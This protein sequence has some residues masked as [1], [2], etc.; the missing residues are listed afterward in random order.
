MSQRDRLE[1]LART[2]WHSP[3][4]TTWGN[5]AVQSASVLLI[6]ALILNRL[7]TIEIAAFYLFAAT[8]TLA[9]LLAQRVSLSFIRLFAFANAGA[10][11]LGPIQV[12]SSSPDEGRLG[13]G[14][15]VP[16]PKP[17]TGPNWQSMR[18]VFSTAGLIYLS[19]ALFAMLVSGLLSAYG[20]Y[21]LQRDGPPTS[22]LWTALIVVSVGSA[23]DLTLRRY[24]TVLRGLDHVA[25]VNRWNTLLSAGRMLAM[26]LVLW[27]GGKL[28][29][30]VIAQQLLL[31]ISGLCNRWLLLRVE[32][33]FRTA[34]TYR[35][36]QDILSAAWEPTWRGLVAQLSF[37]GIAQLSGIIFTRWG[38][39]V[40]VAGYLLALRFITTLA[41][42]S[43][44]PFAS[45]QPLFSRL[46]AAGRID[47][48]RDTIE[49][50]ILVSLALFSVSCLG[51]GLLIEPLL[52]ILGSEVTF[53]PL[54]IWWVMS[55]LNLHDRFNILSL[56]VCATANVILY[57]WHQLAAMVVSVIA[58]VLLIGPL[59]LWGIVLAIGLPRSII[60]AWGPARAAAESLLQGIWSYIART[61]LA[62]LLLHSLAM[63]VG[64]W[65]LLT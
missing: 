49:R 6:T 19:C 56:G 35:L 1:R 28:L 40:A 11:E 37:T 13:T 63:A 60:M 4:V 8:T 39:P 31:G 41:Q 33:R 29:A 44:A 54:E 32:P 61:Y 10:S 16:E 3:T 46:R 58:L 62:V 50:R 22:H 5:L 15:N 9:T 59:G 52:G 25:L 23:I 65:L 21:N 57:H 34:P 47:E 14:G 45:R 36:H 43:Q 38:D 64:F 55:F 42:L 20:I 12:A 27:L 48:L 17:E 2:L 26:V 53:I 30:L 51:L 18:R 7:T 24:D